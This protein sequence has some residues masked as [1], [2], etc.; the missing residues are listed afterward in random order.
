[1]DDHQQWVLGKELCPILDQFS[2]EIYFSVQTIHFMKQLSSDL[3]QDP[4]LSDIPKSL[5]ILLGDARAYT[6]ALQFHAAVKHNFNAVLNDILDH[7]ANLDDGFQESGSSQNVWKAMMNPV[8]PLDGPYVTSVWAQKLAGYFSHCDEAIDNYCEVDDVPVP[9]F[10]KEDLVQAF[11]NAA[12]EYNSGRNRGETFRSWCL[13]KIGARHLRFV[14]YDRIRKRTLAARISHQDFK[15]ECRLDP[16][17]HQCG[18]KCCQINPHLA[19]LF[20]K[21]VSSTG[22]ANESGPISCLA[23][24][25]GI[26]RVRAVI[27]STTCP[28]TWRGRMIHALVSPLRSHRKGLGTDQSL[29]MIHGLVAIDG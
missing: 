6:Q 10:E 8:V 22:E 19:S 21:D 25:P 16:S 2:R 23:T 1:M 5:R 14:N 15:V 13:Q 12:N 26:L 28:T 29:A 27:G 17:I 9:L 11:T 7:A 24:I 20:T 3:N 18:V 4:H